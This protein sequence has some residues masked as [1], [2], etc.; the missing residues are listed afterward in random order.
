MPVFPKPAFPF[1]FDV[2]DE[3][4]HLRDWKAH[5]LVPAKAAG[6]ILV[7]T[8]NIANFGA[9][10]REDRHLR[11]IAEILSWFD[12][13]SIQET[14]ENFANLDDVTRDMGGSYKMLFS[15]AAGNDERMAFIYDSSK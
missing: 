4:A 15:D 12:I 3:I 10:Q 11:L 2:A 1:D 9:Q 5:R 6:R 7:G 13:A 8:W 14:R